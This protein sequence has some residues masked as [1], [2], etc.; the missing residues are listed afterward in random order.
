[1]YDSMIGRD[2]YDSS[3]DYGFAAESWTPVVANGS[4]YTITYTLRS[5]NTFHNGDPV[6]PNDVKFSIEF[7]KACGPGVA[8]GYSSV[9]YINHVTTHDDD[10]S[11][12]LND[13]KVWF[14]KGSYWDL[15]L[16]GYQTIHDHN[17]WMAAS[18]ADG[19]G[20]TRGLT[21]FNAFTNRA[22]V[23]A[24]NP[25]LERN[26]NSAYTDF[27]GDGSGPWVFDTYTGYPNVPISATTSLSLYAYYPNAFK[28]VSVTSSGYIISQTAMANYLGW[29]F[30]L[31]GDINVDKAI[32]ANDGYFIGQ[33]WFK[34]AFPHDA[35][36]KWWFDS[37]TNATITPFGYYNPNADI[38]LGNW[39]MNTQ[40]PIVSN[41]VKGDGTIN[42]Y[43]LGKWGAGY[44]SSP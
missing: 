37:V 8:W 19:W 9:I 16:A 43:D 3:K 27:E 33:A 36:H 20:Y 1:M 10:P 14:E 24:Y 22:R 2:P 26:Y 42:V 44:G 29:S 40:Q 39:D 23:R 35:G 30:T 12:G 28:P 6:T 32:D 13:V 4:L 7:T 11:L 34:D 18:A 17:I 5:G 41:G 25:W 38:N 21:D 15:H 31:Q